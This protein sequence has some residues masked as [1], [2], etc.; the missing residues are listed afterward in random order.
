MSLTGLLFNISAARSDKKRDSNIP[1]PRGISEHRNISYGPHAEHSL[2]DVYY[3]KGVTGKLPTI[4]SIHGGGYVYGSKEIY[5]RYGMDMAGR[6]FAFINFNYRLAPK[7]RFPTPLAD[8]GAVLDWVVKN[9]HRYHLD[10]DRIILLGDSAGAQLASHYASITTN[11]EFASLFDLTVPDIQIKALGLNCGMYDLP[12]RAG[13]RPSGL[14][15]DY[16]GRKFDTADPRIDVLSAIRE[17]YPPAYLLTAENDFLRDCAEPM[18]DFLSSKG[19]ENVCKCY[20]TPEQ[21]HIAHVFHV[22]I[23]NPEA[24]VANDEQCAF[25]RRFL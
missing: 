24:T 5:R 21:K 14:A 13:K 8:T 16:L 2:L 23:R 6:G 11:P 9:Q 12:A 17:N 22:D 15:A 19:I 1:I 25:F 18:A 20:G 7:W 4:V 3:P 10:P